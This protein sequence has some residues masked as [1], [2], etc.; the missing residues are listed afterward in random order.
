MR[1]ALAE[2]GQGG[3]REEEAVAPL[4]LLVLVLQVTAQEGRG[5]QTMAPLALLA[6]RAWAAVHAEGGHYHRRCHLVQQ[7]LELTAQKAL[8]ARAL[9]AGAQARRA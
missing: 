8:L 5:C 6:V 4:P 9:R 7:E 3:H 2:G 1:R